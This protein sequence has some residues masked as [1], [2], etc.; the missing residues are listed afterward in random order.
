MAVQDGATSTYL[1][2]SKRVMLS[3][4]RDER[5]RLGTYRAPDKGEVGGSSPPRPTS[6]SPGISTPEAMNFDLILLRPC[7]GSAPGCLA[8]SGSKWV[9]GEGEGC[10]RE[11][12][13]VRLS[14]HGN[15][16]FNEGTG[17]SSCSDPAQTGPTDGR[18]AGYKSG[19]R[20]HRVDTAPDAPGKSEHC[21]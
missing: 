17:C 9:V 8:G 5:T 4:R 7:T 2:I 19:G 16:G 11:Q 12:N 13:E 15:E 20:A 6:F 14:Y 10:W 3:S 1:I 18:P 21:Y